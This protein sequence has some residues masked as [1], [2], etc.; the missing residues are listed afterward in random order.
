MGGTLIFHESLELRELQRSEAT[1]SHW[2]PR[3]PVTKGLGL[4]W[5]LNFL[6]AG[7]EKVH[8]GPCIGEADLSLYHKNE[9]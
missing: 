9:K 7:G 8:A 1:D 3:R 5:G 6:R 2:D 4:G